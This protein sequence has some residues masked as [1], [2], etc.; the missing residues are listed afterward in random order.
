[1]QNSMQ[2]P[3]ILLHF[4]GPVELLLVQI[5]FPAIPVFYLPVLVSICQLTM[6]PS[7]LGARAGVAPPQPGPCPGLVAVPGAT[8][9]VTWQPEG[10]GAPP[11]LPVAAGSWA[12]NLHYMDRGF[13]G[14]SRGAGAGMDAHPS[15]SLSIPAA[16]RPCASS[17]LP[18]FRAVPPPHPTAPHPRPA[19]ARGA[20]PCHHPPGDVAA[21]PLRVPAPP[22]QPGCRVFPVRLRCPYRELDTGPE[23]GCAPGAGTQDSWA[24]RE[25]SGSGHG[26]SEAPLCRPLLGSS[27]GIPA[28]AVP[29]SPSAALPAPQIFFL[30]V[31]SLVLIPFTFSQLS[32]P[33][34]YHRH[35]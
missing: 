27:L 25:C 35:R 6:A 32:R 7:L 10:T 3:E 16:P 14:G 19:P 24:E 15:L 17:P 20:R 30:R 26:G 1:M 9:A 12:V 18:H 33:V 29:G 13:L 21:R 34:A 28:P 5:P 31:M 8:S 22:E 2:H 23:P 4:S 11:V